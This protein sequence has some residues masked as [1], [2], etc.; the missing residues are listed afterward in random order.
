MQSAVSLSVSTSQD[1]LSTLTSRP[2]AAPNRAEV[3]SCSHE[4]PGWGP[5]REG[6]SSPHSQTQ[7][8][9]GG[10]WRETE[11]HITRPSHPRVGPS[12]AALPGARGS[13][14]PSLRGGGGAGDH[15]RPRV[16]GEYSPRGA[17]VGGT[18]GS[19]V[20][21][22]VLGVRLCEP[23]PRENLRAPA[24][25]L[26]LVQGPTGQVCGP[27]VMTH[28]SPAALQGKGR[29]GR[30]FAPGRPRQAEG[31]PPPP[32]W[33]RPCLRERGGAPSAPPPRG[34]DLGH[35]HQD[36]THRQDADGRCHQDHTH[37]G[38]RGRVQLSQDLR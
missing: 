27:A 10:P 32:T 26:C 36:C 29:S 15:S 9:R 38:R 6:W 8:R 19:P 20:H 37:T 28:R 31:P 22:G 12:P 16:T 1:G 24:C 4:G 13:E 25:D 33:R 5:G 14:E 3:T 35:C 21:L 23:R 34:C 17:G 7:G 11:E 18:L 30:G 2:Q